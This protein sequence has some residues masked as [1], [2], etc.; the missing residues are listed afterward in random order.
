MPVRWTDVRRSIILGGIDG[1]ITS[2][3]VVAAGDAAALAVEA[4]LA[5]GVASVVADGFSMGVSEYVSVGGA[6]APGLACFVSFVLCGTVPIAVYVATSG[7]LLSCVF[8]GLAELLALG[9]L[10][11]APRRGVL[12]GSL[13]TTGLGAAAGAIAYAVALLAHERQA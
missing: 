3:A 4:V 6:L 5:V 9:V 8:F 11:E 1:T 12:V 2:F 10:T 7:V 13:V